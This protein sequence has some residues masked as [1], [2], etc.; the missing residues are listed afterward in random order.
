MNRKNIF[1]LMIFLFAVA[2]GACDKSSNTNPAL[3]EDQDGPIIDRDL[4][5]KED[6]DEKNRKDNADERLSHQQPV[7]GDMTGEAVQSEESND[8]EDQNPI[9]NDKDKLNIQDDGAKAPDEKPQD[10]PSEAYF[11]VLSDDKSHMET[12]K[13]LDAGSCLGDIQYEDSILKQLF[14]AEDITDTIKQR[15]EGKSYGKDCNI[16]YED[17]RYIRALHIGFDHKTYIGEMIVNKA[18]AEDIIEILYELYQA[19]YPIERMVL[20]DEY[21]ADDIKSMEA[22]NSSAFNYRNVEGTKRLSLH[23]YGMAVDI[24][25]LYNPYVRELDGKIDVLPRSGEEYADRTKESPYYIKK[26]DICY[27]A[28]TKRGFTW[29][30]EWKNSKDYQHFQKAIDEK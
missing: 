4:V 5:T 1:L 27:Q 15:I 22:N 26:G 7:K 6:G 28:F 30:G 2:A 21:D 24:N 9:T 3:S 10:S 17:L 29:G 19:D 20:V 12:I 16:P 11:E 25:P 8:M 14:Y 18:I 23:S 13:T